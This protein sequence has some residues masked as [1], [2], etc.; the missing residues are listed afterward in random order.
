MTETTRDIP[1]LVSIGVLHMAQYFPAAFTAVALPFILRKEGLPLEMFWLLA[2]PAVPRWL[3]WAIALIVDNYGN[4][5]FGHRKSWILPCT[6]IGAI[7]YASLAWIPPSI[8]AVYA[9]VAILTVKSFVMAAQDI[10]VDGYAAESMTDAERPV[11]TSIIV[12]LATTA[13]VLGAGTVALVEAFGW[14]WTMFAASLLLLIAATPALLRHEAPPPLATLRR[15]ERGERPDLIATLRRT[16]SRYIL[17]FLFL[18]GFGSAFLNAM[19]GPFLADRGLTLTQFGIL[20]PVSVIA[21]FGAGAIATPLLVDRLGMRRTALIGIALLPLE[22]AF[23]CALALMPTL[24]SLPVVAALFATAAFGVSIYTFIVNNSRFRWVSKAQAGTDY[25]LHS[26][27]WN[28]GIWVAGS[29]A[30][31]VAGALG[32]VTFFPLAA[33]LATAFGV[34]YFVTFDRIEALVQR[35]EAAEQG[36]EPEIARVAA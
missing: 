4:E 17:P 8:A 34:F 15:R 5:R 18:F 24:P 19:V 3:K 35:R 25:S 36:D 10:A 29:A 31:V 20:A 7:L 12:F 1:K 6:V 33:A 21:A 13:T 27:I 26:S 11:G 16:E 14:S 22:G 2:L 23:F 32:W 28:F 30:G 9:I